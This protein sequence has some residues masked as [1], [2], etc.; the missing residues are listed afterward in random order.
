MKYTK[1]RELVEAALDALNEAHT[2]RAEKE[3]VRQMKHHERQ[4][5]RASEQHRWDDHRKHLE[6][7][8]AAEKQ[9]LHQG[10]SDDIHDYHP[11]TKKF[12][13]VGKL[14]KGTAE[15]IDTKKPLS[16]TEHAAVSA[17]A[18]KHGS[19]TA[20]H[21]DPHQFGLYANAHHYTQRA[22]VKDGKVKVG[23]AHRGQ[24]DWN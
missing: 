19:I 16:D 3:M 10:S 23:N 12:H 22:R 4:A 11:G 13:V 21:P 5:D 8:D 14:P 9:Y 24:N 18:G 15:K 2:E 20:V 6:D 1:A 17:A 7:H